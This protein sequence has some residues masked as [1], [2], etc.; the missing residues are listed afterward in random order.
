MFIKYKNT[1]DFNDRTQLEKIIRSSGYFN[2]E[3]TT[4]ALELIDDSLK[5]QDKSDYKL[6]II[7]DENQILGYSCY[8]R[9]PFTQSSYDLYWIVIDDK[10]RNLGI[11]SLLLTKTEEN[12]KLLG[13]NQ[14]Y[15]ETS[16]LPLYTST[17]EFYLKN[18]Y[19]IAARFKN[20]YSEGNDKIVF[21]KRI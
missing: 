3:E 11:G 17:V 16:G 14:I 1:C 12:I 19:E 18:K 8:G 10:Y 20:F 9:I 4:I 6:L 5:H 15:I 2:E 21:V 7:E 13:G